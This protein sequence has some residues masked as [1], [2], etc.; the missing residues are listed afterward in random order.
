ML[1]IKYNQHNVDEISIQPISCR[2]LTFG[3][4][5]YLAVVENGLGVF[6]GDEQANTHMCCAVN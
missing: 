2:E 1:A 6:Y 3:A 5:G 4:S